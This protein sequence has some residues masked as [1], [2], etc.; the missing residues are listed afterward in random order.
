VLCSE[1]CISTSAWAKAVAQC[2]GSQCGASAVTNFVDTGSSTCEGFG[3]DPSV[4]SAEPISIG[5]AAISSS[6][7]AAVSAPQETTVLQSTG[8]SLIVLVLAD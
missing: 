8:T 3:Y 6:N 2:I 5:L 4:P 7:I 1:L